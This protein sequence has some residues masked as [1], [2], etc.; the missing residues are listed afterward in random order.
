MAITSVAGA[1]LTKAQAGGAG[2]PVPLSFVS[3]S[4]SGWVKIPTI[5]P[6]RTLFDHDGLVVI[7]INAIGQIETTV[8]GNV[9]TG[10]TIL[11]INKWIYWC[12]D[13]TTGGIN[14]TTIRYLNC[15]ANSPVSTATF[16]EISIT[17]SLTGT[18]TK[19]TLHIPA[20]C[21]ICSFQYGN[22]SSNLVA[23]GVWASQSSSRIWSCPLR[24]PGDLNDHREFRAEFGDT[25]F[26]GMHE[27]DSQTGTITL[28]S[29]DPETLLNLPCSAGLGVI[30]FV[31]TLDSPTGVIAPGDTIVVAQSVPLSILSNVLPST[32]V[33]NGISIDGRCDGAFPPGSISLPEFGNRWTWPNGPGSFDNY[34]SHGYSDSFLFY[35]VWFTMWSGPLG[36]N[37]PHTGLPITL[38]ELYGSTFDV[39]ARWKNFGSSSLNTAPIFAKEIG[40]SVRYFG[41][42]SAGTC[43]EA[44][45]PPGS[46][47]IIVVK[48]VIQ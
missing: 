6:V 26:H 29:N 43:N 27:W 44:P 39:L 8:N 46:G 10:T 1:T 28:D 17:E 34:A 30:P 5:G 23:S 38:A 13:R 18:P 12:W 42:S 40:I 11:P 16:T 31:H 41:Q 36:L 24:F 37:N 14:N 19:F 22:S 45:P 25:S 20:G 32:T 47:R 33:L 15:V 21:S 3:H 7:K 4:Y 48:Q 35:W 2:F 9:R